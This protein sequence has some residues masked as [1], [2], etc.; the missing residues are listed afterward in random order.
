V[1]P[2][3]P[4]LPDPATVAVVIPAR[5]AGD[6]VVTALATATAQVPAVD[7]VVVACAPEDVSTREA[8]AP[9]ALQDPRVRLVDAPGGTTPVALNAGIAATTADVIVRLD[10]HAELPDG[11]VAR[12]VATL[13]ATGAGN[14]GGRQVPVA[15]AGFARAV[16][17]AMASPA[18]AGG[19]AYRT[20][21]TAGPVD[22]V[23]LGAFR[24]EA[25][26]A[27]EGYHAG[28]V[29]NQDAELNLRLA[30]AGYTVWFD[31]ELAVAYRPRDTVGGL[32]RQYL[33]YGR[34]RRVTAALHRASLRP[35]QLA[36]PVLVA[37]LALLL[38][39]ALVTGWWV[40]FLGATAGYLGAL[41]VAGA[42]AA[43][44][45][46][47]ALPTAVALGTM[48]LAW[49]L[50]FLSGPPRG[51]PRRTRTMDER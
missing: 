19:A 42:Q 15:E 39:Q 13:R 5:E 28:M 51:A 26:E 35:R 7:E 30:A 6:T 4:P 16:A 49:G 18:G 12:A 38:L 8:V 17:A 34:W 2:P 21:S 40:L 37:G 50:G 33:G 23:Y 48:H 9:V 46:R 47:S 1:T 29:R 32:A 27:V 20:G 43:P 3:L 25:L 44:T 10:A 22:T 24:R 31:P 11:Y 45:P 41:V 14:V 36:A